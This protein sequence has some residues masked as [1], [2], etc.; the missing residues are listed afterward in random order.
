MTR[1]RLVFLLMLGCLPVGLRG[2]EKMQDTS[3]SFVPKVDALLVSR[4]EHEFDGEYSRFQVRRARLGVTGKVMP[5]I[6]YRL[7]VDLCDRGKFK[8]LDLNASYS[9]SDIV[10]LTA[11]QM[12]MPF[13]P[14][15]SANPKDYWFVNRAFIGKQV[16]NFRSVGVKAGWCDTDGFI[17]E[18]GVFNA[19]SITDHTVWQ[20]KFALSGRAGYDSGVFRVEIGGQSIAPYGLRANLW[21]IYAGWNGGPIKIESEFARKHFC[22]TDLKTTTAYAVAGRY[23]L[24]LKKCGRFDS[25]GFLCRFDGM[26][27]HSEGIPDLETGHLYITDPGRKRITVGTSLGGGY[28]AGHLLLQLNYEHYFYNKDVKVPEGKGSRIS[29]QFSIWF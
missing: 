19:T 26:T 12:R 2:S 10:K 11:G 20:K 14:F 15:A 13:S 4:F 25:L 16:S 24:P 8:I 7:L 1:I 29:A 27:D 17:V 28:K 6:S 3:F 22:N 23:D 9:F 18:G 5:E 21:D